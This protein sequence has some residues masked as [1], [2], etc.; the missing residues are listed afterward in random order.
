MKEA[1]AQKIH[2]FTIIV[3]KNDVGG[4]FSFLPIARH[5]SDVAFKAFF[6]TPTNCFS[7]E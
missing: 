7:F 1:Q 2:P 5:G 3:L 4:I 6:D